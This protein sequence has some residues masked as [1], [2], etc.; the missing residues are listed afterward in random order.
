MVLSAEAIWL[1]IDTLGLMCLLA[2]S[3]GTVTRISRGPWAFRWVMGTLFAVAAMLALQDPIHVSDGVQTDLRGVPLVLAGAYLGWQGALAAASLAL[4]MRLGIGGAGTWPGCLGILINVGVGLGWSWLMRR[5]HRRGSQRTEPGAKLG[6]ALASS[7]YLL[8]G[9]LLPSEVAWRLVTM[10][11]PVVLPLHVAGVIIVAM[12]LEREQ[13]LLDARRRIAEEAK[14]DPLTRLLNRRGFEAAVK[15]ARPEFTG[16][17]LLL[18]DLD[19]FKRVNDT[20]GHAAGDAVLREVARRLSSTLQGRGIIARLGGEEIAVFLPSI[21]PLEAGRIAEQLRQAVRAKPVVL[22]CGLGLS[23]TTSIGGTHRPSMAG[24][25]DLDALLARAD[26]GLYAAK[27]GG[28]DRCCF[29]AEPLGNEVSLI[30][31]EDAVA[32]EQAVVAPRP[33]RVRARRHSARSF[34]HIP[35]RM[36]RPPHRLDA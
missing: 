13:A 36:R 27:H 19:R 4:A 24:P 33:A 9:L 26:Q 22:P 31:L 17:A 35:Q 3:Y 25:D 29:D 7:A 30:A 15:D 23:V 10:A 1:L 20:H 2:A 18:L 5:P 34:H 11:W 21:L 6:L 28:R 16:A 32:W 14:R 12:V 8:P